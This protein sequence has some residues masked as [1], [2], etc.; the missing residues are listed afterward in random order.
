MRKLRG[1]RK[2]R[3][4]KEGI[5]IRKV[6]RENIKADQESEKEVGGDLKK[7]FPGLLPVDQNSQW[8]VPTI[9][10]VVSWKEEAILLCP[11]FHLRLTFMSSTQFYHSDCNATADATLPCYLLNSAGFIIS[12]PEGRH[13]VPLKIPSSMPVV[14]Q[15]SDALYHKRLY[16]HMSDRSTRDHVPHWWVANLQQSNHL[17]VAASVHLIQAPWGEG[18]DL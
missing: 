18:E 7:T 5:T 3:D 11:S 12:S 10:R 14:S 16:F 4:L 15:R 17:H 9:H 13:A 6:E 1:K 8:S 2:S